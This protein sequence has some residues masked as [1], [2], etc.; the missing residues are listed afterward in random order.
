[1]PSIF[2][3]LL[4]L[5]SI[6]QCLGCLSE[7]WVVLVAFF[8]SINNYLYVSV[9]NHT[10]HLSSQVLYDLFCLRSHFGH[11]PDLKH[12]LL[13]KKSK[14]NFTTSIYERKALTQL[15]Y[16]AWSTVTWRYSSQDYIRHA[17]ERCNMINYNPSSV[18]DKRI[19]NISPT[20]SISLNISVPFHLR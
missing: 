8:S 13:K 10:S 17:Y 15:L 12:I 7:L 11:Q 19:W 20:I 4:N 1:M 16:C 9:A 18:T 2:S 6:N 5:F 14:E 3:Q